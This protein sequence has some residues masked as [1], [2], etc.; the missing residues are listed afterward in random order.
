MKQILITGANR[1]IGFEMTKQL[2]AQGEKV[3][4]TCRHPANATVL[5]QL[6]E[7]HPAQVVVVQMDVADDGSV[8]GGKTAVSQHT[9]KLDWLINN[10]GINIEHGL[11]QFDADT[12]LQT[13]NINAVGAMRVAAQFVD[14]LRQG[15]KA[16]LVNISS[17]LGSLTKAR[18]GWGNYSYN[19]SK[20]AMNMISRHLA[21]D[22]SADKIT[23]IAMHPGWVQTDMGGHEA[24]VTVPDSAAG[25]IRV[26]QSLTHAD[27]GK[28]F[29]YQGVEH[30]W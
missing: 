22:L 5:S 12:M 26:A 16:K 3:F 20:S 4:A 8:A 2:V 23:V 11:S 25:I 9:T 24:A 10:A 28:F 7:Q 27:T 14:L 21:F 1:G 19:A 15:E 17:Q 29:T 13:L 18:K 30:V 6:A